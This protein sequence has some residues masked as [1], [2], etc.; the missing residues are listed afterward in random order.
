MLHGGRPSCADQRRGITM[1][2]DRSVSWVKKYHVYALGCLL[3]AACDNNC[4]GSGLFIV[5]MHVMLQLTVHR[6]LRLCSLDCVVANQLWCR[7]V[8]VPRTLESQAMTGSAT[9]SWK[10]LG[11]LLNIWGTV[12]YVIHSS[13]NFSCLP[14]IAR[15]STNCSPPGGFALPPP[16]YV[17]TPCSPSCQSSL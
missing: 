5:L 10:Y 15:V 11:N 13:A 12:V 1:T 3:A 9:V 4:I 8:R 16:V 17:C 6:S 2:I 7:I 14:L